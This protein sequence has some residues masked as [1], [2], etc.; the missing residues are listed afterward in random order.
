MHRC[1]V[2]IYKALEKILPD[3]WSSRLVL[4]VFYKY[5]LVINHTFY[6]SFFMQTLTL[7]SESNF[8]NIAVDFKKV[9]RIKLDVDIP[10]ASRLWIL[11]FYGQFRNNREY[12]IGIWFFFKE[13]D[14]SFHLESI[15]SHYPHIQ[16]R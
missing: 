7:K 16:I 13:E 14:R 15:L 8:N 6:N 3:K 5:I 1:R 12:V 10:Q 2:R 4:Y 11:Y 9:R